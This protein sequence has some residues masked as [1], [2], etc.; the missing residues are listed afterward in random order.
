MSEHKHILALIILLTLPL[1]AVSI[2]PKPVAAQ[3]VSPPPKQPKATVKLEVE[4]NTVRDAP[5]VEPEKEPESFI[6]RKPAP[7][8]LPPPE[9][10][11]QRVTT[12]KTR[13]SAIDVSKLPSGEVHD[14]DEAAVQPI[15]YKTESLAVSRRAQ[16]LPTTD[17]TE[18][19]KCPQIEQEQP[20]FW[21]PR[22]WSARGASEPIPDASQALSRAREAVTR[23]RELP[24]STDYLETDSPIATPTESSTPQKQSAS[25]V[26]GMYSPGKTTSHQASPK[27][28]S[29]NPHSEEEEA[30]GLMEDKS[31]TML[32]Y[33]VE[34]RYI[35]TCFSQTLNGIFHFRFFW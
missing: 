26:I 6:I 23:S 14:R 32:A 29:F 27:E 16:R 5:P 24:P 15:L 21:G 28:I 8:Q 1:Q 18:E 25:P 34:R 19:K 3:S 12:T 11:E 10:R 31:I 17:T 30:H 20:R 9:L 4:M 35:I 7:Y 33:P 2:S 22:P 13:S